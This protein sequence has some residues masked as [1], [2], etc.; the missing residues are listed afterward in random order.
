MAEKIIFNSESAESIQKMIEDA[1]FKNIPS[2][3]KEIVFNRIDNED[4][5]RFVRIEKFNG[6]NRVVIPVRFSG[7]RTE[8]YYEIIV[9]KWFMVKIF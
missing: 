9:Q 7:D 1:E 8:R 4:P 6:A 2:Y 5:T 3:P